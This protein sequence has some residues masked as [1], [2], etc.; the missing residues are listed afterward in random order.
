MNVRLRDATIGFSRRGTGPPL[1][2]IHGFTGSAA[3]MEPL[4]AIVIEAA[5]PL[6]RQ[7]VAVDL[8]GHGSSSSPAAIGQYSMAASIEH[9][10]AVLDEVASGEPAD[11]V[12]YS[13]GGRVALSFAAAHPNRVRTLTLIGATPGLDNPDEAA[14]RRLADER[15]ADD[16][17]SDGLERFVDRWMALPMWQSLRHRIGPE[18]WAA[19]RQQRLSNDPTGLSNSLRGIS[20]GVMPALHSALPSVRV[21]TLLIAGDEDQKFQSI[22]RSMATL[23]PNARTEWINEAGHAAHLEQPDRTAAAIAAHVSVASTVQEGDAEEDG[24]P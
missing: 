17:T 13:L 21:P 18:A 22:A 3:T 9:V 4:G 12:G 24:H 19:S 2:L 10:A 15:L 11:I 5:A 6:T 20:T 8:V 14:A 16:L 1:L 23:L 7:L